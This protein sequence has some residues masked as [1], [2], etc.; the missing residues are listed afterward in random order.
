MGTMENKCYVYIGTYTNGKSKGIYVLDFNTVTGRLEVAGTSPELE[1]PSYLAISKDIRF[2]YAVMETEA[3]RGEYGGA[4]GAYSIDR[5]TG[6]LT[7]LNTLPTKGTHPCH[8]GVDSGN[9]FLFVSNY[10]DGTLSMFPLENNGYIGNMSSF[11]RHKGSGPD[12]ARQEG[13]HMHYAALTPDEKYLCAV[14]L[15]IDKINVYGFSPL[16]GSTSAS[17]KLSVD[18]R[19]GSGPRH[20]EFSPDNKFAYVL[21]ELSSEVVVFKYDPTSCSFHQIQTVSTLPA[22]C[23]TDNYCAAVHI[24]PAGDFLYAS[25]RGHDSLAVFKIDQSSGML[26]GVSHVSTRG[27]YP[28]DFAIDPSGKFLLAANQYSDTLTGYA[29]KPGTGEPEFLGTILEIP[30]PVCIKFVCL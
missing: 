23:N 19:P 6:L 30:S 16:S 22:N 11:I 10:S 26:E 27:A 18:I 28:R 21:T 12:K 15:G 5:Q 3:Y 1:N 17:Q 4:V 29:I 25:N 2:L 13:P 24:S 7:L 20:M 9:R 8:L 14:D